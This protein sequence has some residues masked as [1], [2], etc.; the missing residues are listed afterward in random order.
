MTLIADYCYTGRV[1]E[2]FISKHRMRDNVNIVLD[3]GGMLVNISGFHNI[4]HLQEGE[5]ELLEVDI[6]RV[7]GGLKLRVGQVGRRL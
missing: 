2:Y 1:V 7:D 5:N 4:T 6:M 3:P